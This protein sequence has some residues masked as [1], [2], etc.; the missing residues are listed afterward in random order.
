[1]EVVKFWIYFVESQGI[2]TWARWRVCEKEWSQDETKRFGLSDQN[3]GV[4]MDWYG[5]YCRRN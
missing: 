4:A 2:F 5:E 3:H 1:M